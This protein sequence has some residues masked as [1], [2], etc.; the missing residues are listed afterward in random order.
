M[1]AGPGGLGTSARRLEGFLTALDEAGVG[2]PQ[3]RIFRGDF[4]A[5]SGRA[6]M[7]GW[8]VS[9]RPP[10]AVFA[11]NDLMAIGTLSAAHARGLD[12]PDDLSVVG[13]DGIAFGADVTP[14]L[15]TVAQ[16][17]DDV[18]A[19]AVELLFERLRDGAAQPRLVELPVALAVRGSSGPPP[20][21]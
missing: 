9:G 14:P 11:E 18:A 21:G 12:V 19:A 3:T 5:A 15:T 4:R 13:F 8:I 2:L 16:S 10:T 6:A 1:V 7:D 20:S 17:A